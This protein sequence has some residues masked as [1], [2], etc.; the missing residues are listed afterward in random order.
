MNHQRVYSGD[1]YKFIDFIEHLMER[2]A[3]NEMH[4]NADS[5]TLMDSGAR[6]AEH[7]YTGDNLTTGGYDHIDQNRRW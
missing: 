7:D 3:E 6:R 2:D 4:A 5:S 1:L